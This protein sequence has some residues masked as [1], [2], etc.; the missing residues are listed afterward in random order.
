[1]NRFVGSLL[2]QTAFVICLF[3][4]VTLKN[5]AMC[6]AALR[7]CEALL[8]NEKFVRQARGIF[9]MCLKFENST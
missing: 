2:Q 6:S 4:Y 7:H 3:T 5:D 1:M 9:V 8:E